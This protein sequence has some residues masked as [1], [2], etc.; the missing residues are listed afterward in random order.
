MATNPKDIAARKLIGKFARTLLATTCLTV[1]GAAAHAG[2]IAYTEGTAPAP[3]DFSNTFAGANLLPA[4]NPT[5]TVTG[6]VNGGDT[7]DFFELTGLG[8]GTFTVSVTDNN[9]FGIASI[10]L[11]NSGNTNLGGPSLF[12]GSEGAS[13]ASQAIPVDGNLIVEINQSNN[14][15][16]ATNYTVTVNTASTSAP[17]PSTIATLGLGLAG[18]AVALSRRRRKQ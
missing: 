7:L 16:S 9:Q 11:L 8:T 2:T 14:N 18:G 17:E 10:T 6:S 3:A 5:T 13:F 12:E 15:E 4:G 1:G